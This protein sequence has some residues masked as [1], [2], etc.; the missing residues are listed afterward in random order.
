[1]AHPVRTREP[2]RARP[3][4]L[5]SVVRRHASD[6]AF[7]WEQHEHASLSHRF[8]LSDLAKIDDQIQAHLRGLSLAGDEGWAVCDAAIEEGPGELFAAAWVALSSA[9][10]QRLTRVLDACIATPSH[11]PALSAASARIRTLAA[12]V[13]PSQLLN[14]SEDCVRLA[15]LHSY[16]VRRTVPPVDLANLCQD[17]SVELQTLVARLIGELRLEGQTRLLLKLLESK[18][19]MVRTSAATSLQFLASSSEQ[20]LTALQECCWDDLGAAVL[21]ADILGRVCRPAAVWSLYEDL[22]RA[23]ERRPIAF[24]LAAATGT[25]SYVDAAVAHLDNPKLTRLAGLVIAQVV[26][27]DLDYSD[28]TT[29]GPPVTAPP[30]V[31]DQVPGLVDLISSELP[32]P[33]PTQV[34]EF[35][36]MRRQSMVADR[37]YQAGRPVTSE[38]MERLLRD[39]TQPQ[40]RAAALELA[41][42]GAHRE[43]YSVRS[44]GLLQARDLLG[45]Q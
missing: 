16:A 1:M 24:V 28:L 4:V 27:L 26:G 10:D 14:H 5:Q 43:L 22:L 32:W 23:E 19:A 37:R 11:W 44:P 29:D 42:C 36:K 40:R 35:W 21:A 33:E 39:G 45:W 7:A 34:K 9:K 25:V 17:G 6:S 8:R 31:D 38:E 12:Q 41:L 3:Y 18:D 15:A 2:P 20:T 30:E 13:L